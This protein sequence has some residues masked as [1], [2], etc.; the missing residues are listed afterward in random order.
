MEQ[1][2]QLRK[3]DWRVLF[4]ADYYLG[5]VTLVLRYQQPLSSFSKK[6]SAG[7]SSPEKN[8]SLGFYLQYNLWERKR[9]N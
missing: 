7:V 1:A 2:L 6:G 9:K 4:E 5:K 3:V 8:T